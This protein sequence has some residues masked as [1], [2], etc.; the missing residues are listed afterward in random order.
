MSI[1]SCIVVPMPTDGP[2]I[3]PITGFRH[4]K[5]RSVTSPPPSRCA[6]SWPSA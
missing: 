5:M 2:L 6:S 4:S 1:G 3:A